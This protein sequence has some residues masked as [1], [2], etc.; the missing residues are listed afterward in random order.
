MDSIIGDLVA[1]SFY[2]SKP[3]CFLSSAIMYV[4]W[5][6]ILKKVYSKKLGKKVTLPFCRPNFGDDYNNDM[7]LNFDLKFT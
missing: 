5:N 4:K 6:I 2:D 3:V 1:H 7:N